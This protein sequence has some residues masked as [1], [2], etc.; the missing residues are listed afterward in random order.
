MTIVFETTVVGR[1]DD[2]ANENNITNVSN[3]KTCG[4]YV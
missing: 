3:C 1:N 2:S 4:N